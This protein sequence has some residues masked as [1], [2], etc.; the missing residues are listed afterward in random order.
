M[1][2][3]FLFYFREGYGL[4]SLPF[5]VLGYASS[6]YYLAVKDN[7]LIL[8]VFPEFKYFLMVAGVGLPVFCA[9]VGWTYM[10][11]SFFFKT[12]QD[13]M[14]E[15]NPYTTTRMVPVWLPMWEGLAEILDLHGIDTA[16]IRKIINASRID[17]HA[18]V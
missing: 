1:V 9:I 3:R 16:N 14:V 17:D 11:R 15:A 12:K 2:K 6:I 7:P 18:G 13:V 5:A 10:K 4:A 8:S